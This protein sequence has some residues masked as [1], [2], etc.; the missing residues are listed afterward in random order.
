MI[1]DAHRL[2][3]VIGDPLSA[4]ICFFLGLLLRMS[5]PW[6][7][8]KDRPGPSDWYVDRVDTSPIRHR[9]LRSQWPRREVSTYATSQ[10]IP[11]RIRLALRG[12][13]G[14]QRSYHA[15]KA[16][17]ASLV[18][19]W[20]SYLHSLT[21]YL[22]LHAGKTS[23]TTPFLSLY[24]WTLQNGPPSLFFHV[25]NVLGTG[26]PTSK[27]L[28]HVEMRCPIFLH[29]KLVVNFTLRSKLSGD[30]GQV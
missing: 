13:A 26:G 20:H 10:R 28:K 30:C 12:N 3:L 17:Q 15:T 7:R 18:T 27:A 1:K 9:G 14:P 25:W 4:Q 8:H 11:T 6:Q 23:T 5:E 2:S 22:V 19:T 16:R 21:G 24:S 29:A